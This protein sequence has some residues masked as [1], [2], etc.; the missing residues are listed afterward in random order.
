MRDFP[1][2]T[3]ARARRPRGRWHGRPRAACT[4]VGPRM[5]RRAEPSGRSFSFADPRF[6]M[7]AWLTMQSEAKRSRGRF[8]LQFA[9][10]REIFMNCSESDR[11]L[12]KFHNVFQCVTGSATRLGAG[13]NFG[14]SREEQRGVANGG[15]EGG[16][17][18]AF[19]C[20]GRKPRLSRTR[21]FSFPSLMLAMFRFQQ[22]TG[23]P[24]QVSQLAL[25]PEHSALPFADF[26]QWPRGISGLNFADDFDE[27]RFA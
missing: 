11:S 16:E 9:I 24:D 8:S 15:R 23:P 26:G 27:S 5:A 3:F 17:S 12:V 19:A 10:C 14:T 20:V 21:P 2:T 6:E 4:C 13:S 22:A 25:E 1:S 7:T 18:C